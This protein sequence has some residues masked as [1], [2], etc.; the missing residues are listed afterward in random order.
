MAKTKRKAHDM[1]RR[2]S[3][4]LQPTGG[5]WFGTCGGWLAAQTKRDVAVA[6]AFGK[7]AICAISDGKGPTCIV[8]DRDAAATLVVELQMALH[9]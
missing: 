9:Q 6:S 8:L 4:A 2:Q 7:I 1:T 3:Q 5:D